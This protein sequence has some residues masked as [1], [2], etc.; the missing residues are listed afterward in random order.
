M[1]HGQQPPWRLFFKKR[2]FGDTLECVVGLLDCLELLSLFGDETVFAS[3]GTGTHLMHAALAMGMLGIFV[4]LFLNVVCSKA[5]WGSEELSRLRN[6]GTV[7]GRMWGSESGRTLIFLLCSFL[8]GIGLLISL[9]FCLWKIS[10]RGA[11]IVYFPCR[12]CL[13]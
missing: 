7:C 1:D 5:L 6:S 12:K 2:N 11:L 3:Q 8:I 13:L 9:W 10:C 4:L